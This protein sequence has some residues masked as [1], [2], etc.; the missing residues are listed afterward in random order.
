M[1]VSFLRIYWNLWIVMTW[2][3]TPLV[4]FSLLI[5]QLYGSDREN[6]PHRSPGRHILVS[7]LFRK[8]L[9]THDE[10]TVEIWPHSRVWPFK[11]SWTVQILIMG[12]TRFERGVSALLMQ[13]YC[14]TSFLWAIFTQV[15]FYF[16]SVEL[17]SLGW[18]KTPFSYSLLMRN[19]GEM[20]ANKDRDGEIGGIR[21][22][23][24]WKLASRQTPIQEAR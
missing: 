5:K 6:G 4:V 11:E 12:P 24:T 13:S 8:H 18:K 2:N 10:S 14:S 15:W 3:F 7:R 9:K 20:L 23:F 22:G 21:L 19:G 17:W 16:T 1:V